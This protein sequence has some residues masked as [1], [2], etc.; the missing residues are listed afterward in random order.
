MHRTSLPRPILALLLL[1]ALWGTSCK[2]YATNK[3]Q[4]Q[5]KPFAKQYLAEDQV[6]DYSD[7]TIKCVDTVTE[8]GYAQLTLELLGN[9]EAANSESGYSPEVQ[10]LMLKDIHD[11]QQVLEALLSEG[12]LDS[13]GVLLYMVTAS[14]LT[15]EQREREFIFFVNADKKSLHTLDPFGDNLVLQ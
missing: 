2:D 6:K 8:V 4:R 7:L 13:K 15:P 11:I 10:N 3:L 12:I 1:C 5:M 14:Y 9:M